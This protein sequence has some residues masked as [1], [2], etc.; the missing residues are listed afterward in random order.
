MATQQHV[1]SEAWAEPNF[2]LEPGALVTQIAEHTQETMTY[3]ERKE[4]ADI[5]ARGGLF[6][7]VTDKYKAMSIIEMGRFFH[8]EPTEALLNIQIGHQGGPQVHYSWQL[9]RLRQLGH[10]Y[11]VLEH[12]HRHCKLRFLRKHRGETVAEYVVEMSVEQASK[13][14]INDKQQGNGATLGTKW[15][16]KAYPK[17][18]VLGFCARNG[19]RW[20]F[21]EV[22]GGMVESDEQ[23]AIEMADSGVTEGREVTAAVRQEN[24]ADLFGDETKSTDLNAMRDHSTEMFTLIVQACERF[25]LLPGQRDAWILR[26]FNIPTLDKVRSLATLKLILAHVEAH[27]ADAF[28]LEEDDEPTERGDDSGDAE[29]TLPG[30][31]VAPVPAKVLEDH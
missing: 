26:H 6:P 29:P 5:M 2:K 25:G 27:Q 16:W 18:M 31:D 15:N 13:I 11:D 1:Q 10:D 8:M 9:K 19:V 28:Q 20:Y 21:P 12:D 30:V 23:V 14:A 3:A 7:G 24:D 22:L 4:L 17:S